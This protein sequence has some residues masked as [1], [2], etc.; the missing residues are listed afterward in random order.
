MLSHS[1]TILGPVRGHCALKT[2][3]YNARDF[4][5]QIREA[6]RRSIVT[7]KPTVNEMMEAYARDAVDHAKQAFGRNLDFSPASVKQVEEILP[8]CMRP[9]PACFAACSREARPMR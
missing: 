1:A 7:P 9:G 8:H 2:L 3:Q 6:A 4:G 5:G